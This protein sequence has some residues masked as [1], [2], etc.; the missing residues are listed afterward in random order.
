MMTPVQKR[1]SE[2]MVL[3]D[4]SIMLTDNPKDLLMLSC[5]ML[6]RAREIMD[7]TIGEDARKRLFSDLSE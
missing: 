7:H 3:I 2:M 5:A 1:M 6:Q 4:D